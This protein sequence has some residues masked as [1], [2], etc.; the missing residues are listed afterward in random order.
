MGGKRLTCSLQVDNSAC[1]LLDYEWH[2]P[3]NSNKMDHLSMTSGQSCQ[4]STWNWRMTN[5]G[6][7]GYMQ[8]SMNI[9]SCTTRYCP[10]KHYVRIGMTQLSN[11]DLCLRLFSEQT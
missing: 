10:I 2:I 3:I 9:L 5:T 6:M 7:P 8:G 11:K 4:C 1:N